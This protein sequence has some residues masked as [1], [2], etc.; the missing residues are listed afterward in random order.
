MLVDLLKAT[1]TTTGTGAVALARKNSFPMPSDHPIFST[2]NGLE[3]GYSIKTSGGVVVETGIGTLSSNGASLA[4]TYVHTTWSAGTSTLTIA[5]NAAAVNLTES[6]YDVDFGLNAVNVLNSSDCREAATNRILLPPN[7]SSYSSSGLTISP[8]L[9]YYIP[10]EVKS[11]SYC[12]GFAIRHT[13]AASPN[14]VFALHQRKN[15]GN[16]SGIIYS[17]ASAQIGTLEGVNT[18]PISGGNKMIPAGQYYISMCCDATDTIFRANATSSC[19]PMNLGANSATH[20]T[21]NV[22]YLTETITAPLAI[23]ASHG[24]LAE[25]HTS[26]VP[27][28]S[29]KSA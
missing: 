19:A 14:Y 22:Q 16:P 23:P 24:T 4:R 9:V 3:I 1:T 21:T 17:S 13:G 28:V 6:S 20:I 18:F 10:F 12:S 26:Y 2:V 5:K 29:L 11:L 8:Y 7:V 27:V 15:N 25:V